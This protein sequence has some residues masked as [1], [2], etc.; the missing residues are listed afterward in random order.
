VTRDRHLPSLKARERLTWTSSSLGEDDAKELLFNLLHWYLESF[1]QGSSLLVSRKLSSAL[2]TFFIHFH[3]LW[4]NYIRHL[5][6]CLASRQVH[7][8]S[9]IDE[10]AD[11]SELMGGL[12]PVQTRAALWVIIN[13]MEDASRVDLN[14]EKK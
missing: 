11:L 7:D 4:K 6:L 10:S 12:S 9:A 8:T 13:V 3:R 2:A 1:T 14:A 5:L